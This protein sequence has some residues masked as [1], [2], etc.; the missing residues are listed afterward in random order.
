MMRMLVVVVLLMTATVGP[1]L[2]ATVGPREPAAA[3]APAEAAA[4]TGL[5]RPAGIRRHLYWIRGCHTVEMPPGQ[6]ESG[7]FT[8]SSTEVVEDCDP[9]SGHCRTTFGIVRRE[10]LRLRIE[11]RLPPPQTESF[12]LCLEGDRVYFRVVRSSYRYAVHA[13]KDG[14]VLIRP[15]EPDP[16]Q[17]PPRP[18]EPPQAPNPSGEPCPQPPQPPQPPGPPQAPRPP[19]DPQAP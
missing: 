3:D 14:V 19:E 17:C 2:G 10:E 6:T 12:E 15:L 8:L 7:R 4:K 5:F 16:G 9:L 1:T 11:N 18:D 13:I